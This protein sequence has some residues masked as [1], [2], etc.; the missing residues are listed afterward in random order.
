MAQLLPPPPLSP[1]IPGPNLFFFGSRTPMQL[2]TLSNIKLNNDIYSARSLSIHR[3]VLVKNFLTLL[4]DSN[5]MLDYWLDDDSY[6]E[7]VGVGSEEGAPSGQCARGREG[8]V[9]EPLLGEDEQNGWIEQ[10]L[11]AAG[12]NYDVDEDDVDGCHR[13]HQ[14]T[15]DELAT[16][17]NNIHGKSTR[18]LKFLCSFLCQSP[19]TVSIFTA[20]LSPITTTAVLITFTSIISTSTDIRHDKDSFTVATKIVFLL[21]PFLR[22]ISYTNTKGSKIIL[23][24]KHPIATQP[25]HVA[26][27]VC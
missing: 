10:T 26:A 4:Y 19:L 11:N 16:G 8:S 23:I 13:H 20:I 14:K 21:T 5:L 1:P 25:V 9:P 17:S 12:L 27:K 18:R 15:K 6:Q 24:A 22:L 2:V 7:G 3:R